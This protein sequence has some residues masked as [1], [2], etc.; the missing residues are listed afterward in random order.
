MIPIGLYDELA[1]ELASEMSYETNLP[2]LRFDCSNLVQRA[3]ERFHEET[4]RTTA[5]RIDLRK[6]IPI[7]AG[8]LSLRAGA[9]DRDK[10]FY[11]T[12]A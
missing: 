7:G 4:G 2:S 5:Y 3:I 6:E 11:P 1:M 8:L 12:R 9:W 10:S